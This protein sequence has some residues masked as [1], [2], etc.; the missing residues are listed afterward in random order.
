M[1]EHEI[2]VTEYTTALSKGRA[3]AATELRARAVRYLADRD[4]LEIE[5]TRDGGFLIPR[6]W[7]GALR[8]VPV[9]E[10]ANIEVWPDG[11]AIELE[12]SNIHISVDG[13]L[14][15]VLPALLPESALATIFA[16]RGG[17][18]TSEAKRTSARANGRKGGRPRKAPA[19]DSRQRDRDGE[20]RQKRSDTLVG[21]LRRTYGEDFAPGY[22]SDAK[23]GTVLKKEGVETLDQLRKRRRQP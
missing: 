16:R 11:S 13:L 7:I 4:M 20:I 1:T 3:E 8:D 21:T 2:S 18:A 5:T 15:D 14:T 19:F 23:L 6:K 9:N 10:L 17:Q 22:R 12:A